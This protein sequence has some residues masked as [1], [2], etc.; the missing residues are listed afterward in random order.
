[1][2]DKFEKV[3]ACPLDKPVGNPPPKAIADESHGLMV[4]GAEI[5]NSKPSKGGKAIAGKAGAKPNQQRGI[6]SSENT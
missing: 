5:I 4:G 1:M 2:T 3:K 6:K